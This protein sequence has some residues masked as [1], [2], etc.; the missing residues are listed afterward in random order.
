MLID[1]NNIIKKIGD[2]RLNIGKVIFKEGNLY[3][4]EG[5][6]GSGKSTFLNI[7]TNLFIQDEGVIYYDGKIIK[8]NEKYIKNRIGF[9]PN[10]IS[11]P[12]SYDKKLAAA[13]FNSQYS[14]FSSEKFEYYLNKFENLNNKKI[15]EMSDGMKKKFMLSLLLAYSPEVL[16]CDE[17]FNDI[18][19]NMKDMLINEFKNIIDNGGTVII[20]SHSTENLEKLKPLVLSINKGELMYRK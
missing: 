10:I 18:D 20:S 2:F 3:L 8:G 9:L 5:E 4:L 14:N 6:N 19:K 13:I 15:S 11:L 17:P 16:I 7:L 1:C 12:G